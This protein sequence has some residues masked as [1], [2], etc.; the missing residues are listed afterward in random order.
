MKRIT[1]ACLEQTI[2]FFDATGTIRP[3]DELEQYQKKMDKRNTRY[4]IL[5]TS[6]ESDGSI[7]IKIKKQYNTYSTDGY[8]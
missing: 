6:K 7:V 2:R 3:E 5:E 4:E 1:S 8:L